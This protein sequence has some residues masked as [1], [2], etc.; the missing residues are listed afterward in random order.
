VIVA[1]CTVFSRLILRADDPTGVDALFEADPDWAGPSLWEAEF[2]SVLRK[3]E[4]AGRLPLSL[5]PLLVRKAEELFAENTC[6]ISMSRA[7]ETSRQTGCSTY[8]SHY[9][10]LAEDLGLKLYTFD[11]EILKKCPRLAR[12]P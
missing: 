4:K 1:D 8:D 2:A 9:I 10:A 12:R 11:T 6:R 7:L 3:Y 5:T